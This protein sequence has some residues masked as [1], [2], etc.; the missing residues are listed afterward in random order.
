MTIS[1]VIPAYNAE[2]YV[3]R[4]IDSVLKQTHP[5]DEIIVVDDGSTDNTAD[6]VQGYGEKVRYIRQENA[7]AGA[8]RNRGIEE[9]TCQ[10]IAFLDSDDEWL[11]DNLKLLAD[12]VSGDNK[13]AWAFGNFFNCDCNTQTRKPAHDIQ[14]AEKRLGEGEYFDNFLVCFAQGFHAWTGSI[15]IRRDVFEN[16][17]LFIVDQ[18]RAEDTDMW[19]RIAYT[20]PQVGY[21]K[22]PMAVY[23]RAVAASATKSHMNFHIISDIVD[24]HLKL[25]AENG[26]RED[27]LPCA[28]CMLCVWIMEMLSA[29]R[30]EGLLETVKRYDDILGWR[31]KKEM[32]LRVKHPR[33]APYC[34]AVTSCIKKFAG[35]VKNI[36]G[37]NKG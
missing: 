25:S 28:N 35:S 37:L 34:L 18:P 24:K 14:K 26:H 6:I 17:S 21:V 27:F 1:V 19:L 23:H 36:L 7:G 22:E 11:A 3:S 2:K 20:Y 31:F 8:A 30:T 13:P 10:W 29:G 5:A 15:L 4:A 32:Y 33:I 9:S 12:V 16:V